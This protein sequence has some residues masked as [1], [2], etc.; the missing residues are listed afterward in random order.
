MPSLI[1]LPFQILD[2]LRARLDLSP[3]IRHGI[4]ILRVVSQSPAHDAGVLPG[5]IVTHIN[6]TEVGKV[7]IGYCDSLMSDIQAWE[8]RREG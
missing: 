2:N 8:S 4:V 7:M 5:D 6:G 1:L 3:S